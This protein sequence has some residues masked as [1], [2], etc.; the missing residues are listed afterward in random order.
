MKHSIVNDDQLD[1]IESYEVTPTR[2]ERELIILAEEAADSVLASY[3][4]PRPPIDP[5]KVHVIE[6]HGTYQA[7]KGKLSG[8]FSTLETERMVIDRKVEDLDFAL[9]GTHEILHQKSP[10]SI[11]VVTSKKTGKYKTEMHRSGIQM[12][13]R[14]NTIAWLGKIEEAIVTEITHE[15]RDI[16][17]KNNP[18]FATQIKETEMLKSQLHELVDSS[19]FKNTTKKRFHSRIN[20]LLFVP[21]AKKMI[22][23]AY[24]NDISDINEKKE[25]VWKY[26]NEASTRADLD[27][28]LIVKGRHKERYRFKSLCERI[29]E[30]SKDEFKSTNEVFTAF[31]QANYSGNILDLV[32]KIETSLGKGS[33][34]RIAE[35]LSEA[36]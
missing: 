21:Q 2:K 4:V 25:A 30:A 13:A 32:R 15:S 7:T 11:R 34:R 24:K 19:R 22:E 27:W 26:F 9:T 35:E 10:K 33:F 23:D 20:D 6:R 1:G 18:L 14:D 28:S 16:F 8:G 17:Y 3:G 12:Y 36:G 31:V 5:A 29:S